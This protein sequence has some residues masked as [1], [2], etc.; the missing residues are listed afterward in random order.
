MKLY[1]NYEENH[2]SGGEICEGQESHSYPD[3]EDSY[4]S[5]KVVHVTYRNVGPYH[6]EFEFEEPVPADLFAV[7]ARYTDGDTFGCT[8]GYGSIEA[9][10]RTPE[11]ARAVSKAIHD[12]SW[13]SPRGYRR[14]TGYFSGLESVDIT[15]VRVLPE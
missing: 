4:N 12:G 5:F 10:V 11:E 6:E 9:L 7:V 14:W 15:L 1:V 13:N 8:H 2:V 3:R